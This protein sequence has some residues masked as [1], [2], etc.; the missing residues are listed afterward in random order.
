MWKSTR[1]GGSGLACMLMVDDNDRRGADPQY[2]GAAD[3]L[4]YGKNNGATQGWKVVDPSATNVPFF[5]TGHGPENP[6][7]F[8]AANNGQYGLT[9]DHLDI[10]EA[11]GSNGGHP[12]SRLAPNIG[13]TAN[14]KDFAGPSSSQLNTFYSS[15]LFLAGDADD[16]VGTLHDGNVTAGQGANDIAIF[17]AFLNSSSNS[18]RKSIWLSGDGIMQDAAERPAPDLYNWVTLTFGSDL[19][20]DNFKVSSGATARATVGF[21]PVASWAHPGRVYGFNHTCTVRADVLS[22]IPTVDG[23]AEAA[24]YE[25]LGPA[26][27][28]ASVYRPINSGIREFST[29]IDGFDLSNLRSNYANLAAVSTQPE[30]DN[31]RLDWFDDVWSAHFQ[32]CARRGPV[33]GVGDLPGSGGQRFANQLLGSFPNPALAN[34]RVTLRFT[35]AQAKNVTIHIYS[36]AGREVAKFAHQGAEGPNNVVWDGSLSNG[37]RATPGVY[38][39]RIEGVDFAGARSAQKMI[40]L[41]SN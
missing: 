6:A 13:F 25:N 26:P 20:F 31:G 32:L 16:Q 11:E 17:D 35:L 1:Y 28:T 18:D 14:K 7:G 8:V 33:V 34:Q 19:A 37:T 9:F 40:L 27:Y 36:V 3:S 5:T 22:V 41:S 23:A 30:A 38:F 39:Y 12:G 29:L 2:R 15:V 24:E 21:L 10:N 4:G